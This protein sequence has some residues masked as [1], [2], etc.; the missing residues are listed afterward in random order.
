MLGS[1]FFL[2][3]MHGS[4]HLQSFVF[5]SKTNGYQLDKFHPGLLTTESSIP[6]QFKFVLKNL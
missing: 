2:V 5:T 1:N 4:L 6:H 3:P